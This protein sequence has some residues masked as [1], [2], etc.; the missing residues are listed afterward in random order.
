MSKKYTKGLKLN[1]F[2]MIFML[3]LA[4]LSTRANVTGEVNDGLTKCRK[5]LLTI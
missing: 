4:H 3:I 2:L 1:I 5:L